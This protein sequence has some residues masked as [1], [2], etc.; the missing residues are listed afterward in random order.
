MKIRIEIEEGIEEEEVVIRCRELSD[1]VVTLQRQ[2]GDKLNS[3]MQIEVSKRD[4]TYYLTLDEIYFLETG[5]NLVVVDTAADSYETK[6]R[7]YELEDMLPGCFMRVSK[8]T[9]IN[10]DKIRSI[11][12]NITGASKVEFN[13][14]KKCAFVSRN[15]FKVLMSKLEEKRL[16]K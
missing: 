13:A 1:E 2:I 14:T 8:S 11:Q 15:Y 6:Q 12:K 3:K 10:T 9:I 7:L 16:K 5:E 4:I